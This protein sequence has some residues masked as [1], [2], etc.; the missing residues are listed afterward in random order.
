M[1]HIVVVTLLSVVPCNGHGAMTWPPNRHGA[2]KKDGGACVQGACMWFSQVSEIVGKPTLGQK[3]RTL[4]VNINGG[5]HDVTQKMPWRAPGTAPVRG[6]GCGVAGGANVQIPNGGS[7]PPG[8]AMGV[9]GLELP[10]T[11]PTEWQIGGVAT[12]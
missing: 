7:P 4:N 8:Y 12:V 11:K 2:E 10:E 9:D 3:F 6:S 5:P 1:W